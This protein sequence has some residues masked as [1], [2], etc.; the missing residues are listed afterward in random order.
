MLG[1]QQNWEE[2]K[3]NYGCEGSG[4]SCLIEKVIIDKKKPINIKETLKYF[5]PRGNQV[6]PIGY[7]TTMSEITQCFD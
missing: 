5:K 2:L 1:N 6:V 4:E 3:K 7:G